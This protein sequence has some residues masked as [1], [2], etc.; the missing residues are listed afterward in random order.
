MPLNDVPQPAQ[1]LNASQNPIRQNF[2]FITAGFIIDHIDFNSGA[3]TGKHQKVT[4]PAYPGIAPNN[5]PV[6]VNTDAV[7]YSKIVGGSPALFFKKQGGGAG[8]AGIDFTTANNATNLGW[9]QL[10]SGTIF[11][12]GQGTATGALAIDT[13][14]I[15][16]NAILNVQLTVLNTGAPATK[17]QL[18]Q[19]VSINNADPLHRIINVYGTFFAGGAPAVVFK[20]LAIGY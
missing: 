9:C 18:I 14:N 19:L 20:W 8:V 16:A 2:Q 7:L 6:T 3:N 1:T 10:P 4:I 5:N 11:S 13:G 17:A 12:W 15:F